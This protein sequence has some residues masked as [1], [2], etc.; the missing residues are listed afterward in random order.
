[1]LNADTFLKK[2]AFKRKLCFPFDGVKINIVGYLEVNKFPIKAKLIT[3]MSDIV[4]MTSVLYNTSVNIDGHAFAL[5][6]W[7]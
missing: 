2:I 7:L 3:Q 1:M 6:Y 5:Q 4:D